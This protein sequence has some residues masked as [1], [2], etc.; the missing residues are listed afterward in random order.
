[1][2]GIFTKDRPLSC[3]VLMI[4]SESR[5]SFQ[6]LLQSWSPPFWELL[7]SSFVA[8]ADLFAVLILFLI[9]PWLQI[10]GDILSP[11][12]TEW[13]KNMWPKNIHVLADL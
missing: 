8:Q 1:M 5:H 9:H 3:A 4:P 13:N 6:L 7:A 11:Q 2:S 10:S 12:F